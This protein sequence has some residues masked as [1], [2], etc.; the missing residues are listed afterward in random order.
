MDF[1]SVKINTHELVVETFTHAQQTL[2]DVL[3]PFVVT[4]HFS[5]YLLVSFYTWSPFLS[6]V[7]I[8]GFLHVTS[9]HQLWLSCWSSFM[10]RP[11]LV[12]YPPYFLSF[13]PCFSPFLQIK[14]R[15]RPMKAENS[16]FFKT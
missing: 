16:Y 6:D 12:F 5:L 1:S 9:L 3:H 4:Y 10:G 7:S 15:T 14:L 11:S 13:F 8:Q 2:R